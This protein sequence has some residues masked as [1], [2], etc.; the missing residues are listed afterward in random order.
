[1]AYTEDRRLKISSVDERYLRTINVVSQ[2]S[3]SLRLRRNRLWKTCTIIKSVLPSSVIIQKKGLD[4]PCCLIKLRIYDRICP[5]LKFKHVIA[6]YCQPRTQ[7]QPS[8][9]ALPL[10]ITSMLQYNQSTFYENLLSTEQR[11]ICADN[12]D[13]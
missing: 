3:F 6:F 1:M 8:R 5:L 7:L 12:T 9:L 4:K 11:V 10:L 13:V 2:T